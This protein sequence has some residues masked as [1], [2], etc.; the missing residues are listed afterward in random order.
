MVVNGGGVNAAPGLGFF[1]GTRLS[2]DLL[3]VY[4][5]GDV[6]DLP[7]LASVFDGRSASDFLGV[8]SF[9]LTLER[10][11]SLPS[12]PYVIEGASLLR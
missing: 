4:G 5:I 2:A 12:L 7:G 9:S 8:Y 3:L 1:A 6:A 10:R 11:L